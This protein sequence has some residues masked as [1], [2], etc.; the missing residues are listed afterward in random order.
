[1]LCVTLALVLTAFTSAHSEVE[2]GSF[3]CASTIPIQQTDELDMAM[4]MLSSNNPILL[5][6]NS[7]TGADI[8]GG[9]DYNPSMFP[10]KEEAS[11][12]VEDA[13]VP[14]VVEELRDGDYL[15]NLETN[16]TMPCIGSL[17]S[18]GI[19]CKEMFNPLIVENGTVCIVGEIESKY[20]RLD[21]YN[22]R[23]FSSGVFDW[24]RK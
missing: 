5:R 13:I 17:A 15:T 12:Y 6:Y 20:I 21:G 19:I 11:I 1:M 8:S 18:Y 16:E 3:S 7:I 23:V 10:R 24:Y 2:L 9:M 22:I 4:G 14:F